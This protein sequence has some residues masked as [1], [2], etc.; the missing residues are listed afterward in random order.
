MGISG[1]EVCW[2][3]STSARGLSASGKL[4]GKAWGNEG[5]KQWWKDSGL[6]GKVAADG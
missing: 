2:K 5:M 6:G 4:C 1:L 3:E